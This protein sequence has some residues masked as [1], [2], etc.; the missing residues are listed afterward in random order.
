MPQCCVRECKNAKVTVKAK[1]NHHA[2]FF[3][4]S[5]VFVLFTFRFHGD[6]KKAR[7]SHLSTHSSCRQTLSPDPWIET[8]DS[9][10]IFTGNEAK[11]KQH[12]TKRTPDRALCLIT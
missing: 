2:I 3:E 8:D 10:F 4:E 7:Y 11:M 6:V 9:E 5:L 1:L 12:E